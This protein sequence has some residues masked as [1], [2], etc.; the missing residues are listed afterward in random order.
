MEYLETLQTA[1][2]PLWNSV[3]TNRWAKFVLGITGFFLLRNAYV[4]VYRKANK[5]PPGPLGN[6]L[7]YTFVTPFLKTKY[8][9]KHH[10]KRTIF[11]DA[12]KKMLKLKTLLIFC[13]IFFGDPSLF[14][15]PKK[16]GH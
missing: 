10:K 3:K 9:T 12:N 15:R 5:Y 8:I 14:V 2:T 1:L 7:F 16:M 13:S 11:I 4:I 6:T